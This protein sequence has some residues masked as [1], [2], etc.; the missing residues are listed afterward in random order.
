MQIA[1]VV[2]AGTLVVL[3]VDRVVVVV[4]DCV[5]LVLVNTLAAGHEPGE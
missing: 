1:E 4:D 2:D 3:E 5:E